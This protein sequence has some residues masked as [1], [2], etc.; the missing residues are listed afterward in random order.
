L[1]Q[2]F[3]F[4]AFKNADE[5]YRKAKLYKLGVGDIDIEDD[6]GSKGDFLL[7]HIAGVSF[8]DIEEDM[9]R[10][11]ELEIAKH[12]AQLRTQQLA[13]GDPQI[14]LMNSASKLVGAN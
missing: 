1:S 10:Q 14:Q 9:K 4:K 13:K 2:S 8:T 12:K 11:G 7:D 6:F 3:Y 5:Y